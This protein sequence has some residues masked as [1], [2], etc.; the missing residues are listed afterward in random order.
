MKCNPSWV[1]H[2]IS[3]VSVDAFIKDQS[4]ISDSYW[5]IWENALQRVSKELRIKMMTMYTRSWQRSQNPVKSFSVSPSL[6]RTH[7]LKSIYCSFSLSHLDWITELSATW[8]EEHFYRLT[9]LLE[10]MVLILLW[11]EN[12]SQV[13][14]R[15]KWDLLHCLRWSFTHLHH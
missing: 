2:L 15:C 7:P 11:L 1:T 6:S 3:D 10:P 8:D 13:L 5:E 14:C 4:G 9:N 12:Q